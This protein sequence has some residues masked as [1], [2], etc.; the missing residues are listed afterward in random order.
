[1]PR[2]AIVRSFGLRPF[3]VNFFESCDQFEIS[4]IHCLPKKLK[5]NSK[6]IQLRLEP[7]FPF[8][9]IS[10]LSGVHNLISLSSWA[11]LENLEEHLE[12]ADCINTI[13]THF[14]LSRQCAEISRRLRKKLVLMVS[15]N[16]LLH[17]S[18]FFLPYSWNSRV[19]VKS[20]DL[21]IAV[22]QKAKLYLQSLS[23][24]DEK[25]R[26]VH[27]GI[28]VDKFHP[29]AQKKNCIPRIL[30]VGDL[31]A[32]KG[33]PELLKAEAQLYKAGFEH[34]LWVCGKGR[35]EPLVHEYS[36]K[37]PVRY[38]GFVDYE[39]LPEIYREC[40]I[41]CLPSRDLRIF[42]LKISQEQFGFSL[43][44]A[45]SSAL[46][47]VTNDSGSKQEVVGS[48]NLVTRKGSVKQLFNALKH[49]V[50][51]ENERVR[52]GRYNRKRAEKFFEIKKQCL[53]FQEETKRIL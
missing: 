4:F 5:S 41:F 6:S 35:L 46:P 2:L 37:Y 38:L 15:Q 45:M 31:L 36:R 53:K 13:E 20:A 27:P 44:E 17:P 16:M 40:D 22:S 29:P 19:A 3:D 34:E 7:V 42:G 8:D 12:S 25:I 21:F 51:D 23:A 50:V 43:L 26:I 39:K 24:D 18:R 14:F 11:I 1:M 49:L 10:R 9:P 30:F 32:N 28:D 52:I 48:E 47:I 33:L